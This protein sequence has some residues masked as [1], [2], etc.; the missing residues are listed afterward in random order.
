M[1]S[2]SQFGLLGMQFLRDVL[3]FL[4]RGLAF[5][6]YDLSYFQGKID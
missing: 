6:G 2:I 3:T 1:T 5:N 4:G